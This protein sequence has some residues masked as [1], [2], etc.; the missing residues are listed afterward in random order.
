MPNR[1]PQL[2]KEVISHDTLECAREICKGAESGHIVGMVVGLIYKRRRYSVS[3]S[4][5]AMEDQTFARGVAMA[6]NDELR[7][8]IHS[9]PKVE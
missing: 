7:E 3:V 1:L 2:V 6:I 4:G 5:F 8:L 9:P